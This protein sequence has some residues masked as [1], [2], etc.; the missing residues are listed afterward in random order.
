MS[1]GGDNRSDAPKAKGSM[2][3]MTAVGVGLLILTVISA[4]VGGGPTVR[5]FVLGGLA[6]ALLIGGRIIDAIRSR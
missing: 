2:G 1:T 6:I 5:S 4:V 3:G